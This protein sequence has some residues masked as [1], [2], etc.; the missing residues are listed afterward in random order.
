[1]DPYD[2][3]AEADDRRREAAAE[4]QR[5]LADSREYRRA[6]DP[7]GEWWRERAESRRGIA[8]TRWEAGEGYRR[9]VL[10]R[11]EAEGLAWSLMVLAAL[12][13]LL[14]IVARLATIGG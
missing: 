8:Q 11:R 13:G 4:H 1:M 9:P 2:A 7:L 14:A 3:A 6:N 12:G 5:S 10:M